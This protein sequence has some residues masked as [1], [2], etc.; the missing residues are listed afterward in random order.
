[1]VIAIK[2]ELDFSPVLAHHSGGHFFATSLG[3]ALCTVVRIANDRVQAN[4][5]AMD[6]NGCR[7]WIRNNGTAIEFI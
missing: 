4:L 3:S 2:F 5:Y 1:M 6:K 7:F